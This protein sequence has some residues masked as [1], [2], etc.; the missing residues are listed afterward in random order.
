MTRSP[1]PGSPGNQ[2][3]GPPR[4]NRPR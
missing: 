1:A 3:P 4:K 2:P